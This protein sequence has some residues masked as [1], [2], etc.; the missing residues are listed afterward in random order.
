[1]YKR[2]VEGE[3]GFSIFIRAIPFNYYALLTIVMMVAIVLMKMD[4]GSMR[5]HE[6][7]AIHG[8]LYTTPDRPY[9]D[10][11]DEIDAV[12]YTH[13]DVYKRQEVE[14]AAEYDIERYV[15][16]GDQ[17]RSDRKI[18]RAGRDPQSGDQQCTGCSCRDDPCG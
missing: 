3:D 12:S 15:D 2:Q 9:A 16:R 13:L 6:M 8:D 17:S 11:E 14:Y 10:A 7:N 18:K 1:M 4:Y 5:Q